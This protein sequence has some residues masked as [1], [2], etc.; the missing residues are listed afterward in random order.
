LS[1]GGI[2]MGG[3]TGTS[4]SSGT[5]GHARV[6]LGVKVAVAAASLAAVAWSVEW[7]DLAR[8]CAGVEPVW[9]VAFA[10]A[11]LVDRVWMAAK[12]RYL[13]AG[14]GVW[15]PLSVALAETLLGNL[16]GMAAQWNFGGDVA[17]AVGVGQ[18]LGRPRQVAA[19]VV[20]EKLAGFVAISALALA[21]LAVLVARFDLGRW[22]T[23]LVPAVLATAGLSL[24]PA[25]A[26]SAR[27]RAPLQRLAGRLPFAA[28][29]RWSAKAL[30]ACAEL[31]GLGRVAWIFLLLTL[32][33]Q[34]MPVVSLF[35][36]NQ[37]FGAPLAPL[38]VLGVTSILQLFS[39][40]PVSIESI[41]V[42]EG[43]YVFLFGMVGVG[44]AEALAIALAWRLVDTVNVAA[45]G[46]AA[47]AFLAADRG[48][49]EPAR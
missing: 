43:L 8:A 46:L 44:A 15:M 4:G 7:R 11:M 48:G 6:W 26:L 24:L 17:R 42:R 3:V 31:S 27:A 47:M 21:G 32:A 2:G 29:R 14:L 13:L 25:L 22:G 28:A 9:L 37:A 33:E 30:E 39:R 12:W 10:A 35:L 38:A 19:S 49:R 1:G 41:G 16:V 20:F 23:V 45:G 34:L 40:L 36:L 18:R 5:G